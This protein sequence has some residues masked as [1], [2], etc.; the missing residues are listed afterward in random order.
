MYV[1]LQFDEA[2]ELSIG[3]DDG[4]TRL[5]CRRLR[6]C[7]QEIAIFKYVQ[8]QRLEGQFQMNRARIGTISLKMCN[9]RSTL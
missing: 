3:T 2:A 9:V 4:H 1:S 5:A 6:A 8:M 7:D